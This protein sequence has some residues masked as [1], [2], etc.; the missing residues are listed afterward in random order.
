M[1]GFICIAALLKLSSA[2]YCLCSD[3]I[4]QSVCDNPST[5]AGMESLKSKVF[6]NGGTGNAKNYHVLRE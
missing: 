5:Y 4:S 6:A 3:I 1:I 2:S